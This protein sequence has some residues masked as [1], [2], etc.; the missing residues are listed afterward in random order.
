[1]YLYFCTALR[2]RIGGGSLVMFSLFSGA[3]HKF[4]SLY[5]LESYGWASPWII[6]WNCGVT[7]D[8]Y[9]TIRTLLIFSFIPFVVFSAM[10]C[11]R[12]PWMQ[13]VGEG[14]YDACLLTYILF[15]LWNT[16]ESS[17]IDVLLLFDI[18]VGI[19]SLAVKPVNYRPDSKTDSH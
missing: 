14:C 11:G 2:F 6:L 1:M 18:S 9:L 7:A 13:A 5:L 4:S 19:H 15:S 10:Y 8:R 12:F 16:H 17:Y 3:A